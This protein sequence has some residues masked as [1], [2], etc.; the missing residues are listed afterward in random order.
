MKFIGE[1]LF[2]LIAF[3]LKLQYGF[4][5]QGLIGLERFLQG[6]EFLPVDARQNIPVAQPNLLEE[7]LA[8]KACDY[9]ASGLIISEMRDE[10]GF[11][12]QLV[13]IL[14]LPG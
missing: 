11:F 2:S 9:K 5:L 12:Q 14:E 3:Y 6:V 7:A 8:R 13:Q 10:T 1:E 4:A